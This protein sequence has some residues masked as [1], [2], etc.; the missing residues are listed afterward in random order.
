MGLT[1]PSAPNETPHTLNSKTLRL[2]KKTGHWVFDLLQG[3]A[4]PADQKMLDELSFTADLLEILPACIG[5]SSR[6]VGETWKTELPAPRGKAYGWIVAEKLEST[7][8]AVE[9]KP[10]G[11]MATITINGKF[12]ME[13]P[14]NVNARMEVTFSAT[15]VRRL[16]DMLD[17]D[18]KITGLLDAVAAAVSDKREPINLFYNYPFTLTRTLK[19]EDK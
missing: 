8:V 9:D 18:T 1:P 3:T 5:N 13:R 2:R 7:L 10:A 11:A 15:V 6:K 14:L 17:V 16:T 12:K 4:S 19:L